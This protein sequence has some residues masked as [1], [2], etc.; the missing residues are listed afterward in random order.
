MWEKLTRHVKS[1]R[2]ILRPFRLLSQDAANFLRRYP[3]DWT[4]FN[5]IVIASAIL[6]FFTNLLPGITFASDL[7]ASTGQN[8]GTIEIV[9]ST[10][11]CNVAS[12]LFGLQPLTILGVTGSFTILAENMYG[13]CTESFGIE[14]LPFTAVSSSLKHVVIF[15]S[16]IMIMC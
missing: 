10:G 16:L 12:A 5:Q 6:V 7:Y 11:L 9:F 8:W 15:D 14:F 4:I 13:L 2:G 1:K 3:S